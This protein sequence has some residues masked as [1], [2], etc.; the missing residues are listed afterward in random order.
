MISVVRGVSVISRGSD[1]A[2][3]VASLV[4]IKLSLSWRGLAGAPG[5]AEELRQRGDR[6]A[7]AI[8]FHSRRQ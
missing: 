3:D 6:K 8:L 1:R 4:L 5:D 2:S 7:D